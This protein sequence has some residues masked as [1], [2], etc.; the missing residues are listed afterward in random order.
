MKRLW[1]AVFILAV[2]IAL[3]GHSWAGPNMKEGL[4]EITTEM[5]MPGMPMAMPGQT[6]RQCID[7][8]HM[9]PS[10]KNGKCKMLSQ[11]TK[12]STVTWHMRCT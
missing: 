5:Q 7:K 1:M 11:K 8:K 9:V 2:A 10:Q 6:F 4:W 3:E 12:G